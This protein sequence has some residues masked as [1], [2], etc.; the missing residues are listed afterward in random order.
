MMFVLHGSS[1]SNGNTEQLTHMMLEGVHAEEVYLRSHTIQPITDQRH[2]AEGF[3]PIHDD[4]EG[5]TKRMLEHDTIVFATPL[6]WYGMSGYMKNF[7]D[8][9]S[10]SLRDASLHFKERM[11]GKKMYVVIVGGDNPKLKA[12]PLIAQFQYIF[13]FVGASFE[14]YIIGA[15]NAPSEIVNDK[16]AMEKV[17]V[18]NH[19]LKQK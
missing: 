1:R 6:Y 13:D 8:R 18:Y 11:Q 15:A 5:I 2:D 14:G 12:L 9:W 16:E 10:Q 3:Q 17:K 19:T 4:Y 7:V